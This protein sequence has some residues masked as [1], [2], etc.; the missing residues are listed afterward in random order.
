MIAYRRRFNVEFHV[1]RATGFSPSRSR[2][3]YLAVA[4][5]FA[6]FAW[7]SLHAAANETVASFKPGVAKGDVGIEAPVEGQPGE[8]PLAIATSGPSLMLLDQINGRVLSLD[9]NT[10][11]LR[12][13]LIPPRV[14]AGDLTIVDGVA[15]VWAGAPIRLSDDESH[16][17]KMASE[18]RQQTRN[19]AA[20]AFAQMGSE[21]PSAAPGAGSRIRPLSEEGSETRHEHLWTPAGVSSV[22]Y[23]L[24]EGRSVVSIVLSKSGKPSINLQLRAKGTFGS[25]EFLSLDGEERAYVLSEILSQDGSASTFVTRFT[26]TGALDA[27]YRLPY[28]PNQLLTTRPVA[29]TTAGDVLFLQVRPDGAQILKL[30]V[31]APPLDGRLGA[32]EPEVP[33]PQKVPRPAPTMAGISRADIVAGALAY[34]GAK[35]TVTPVAYGAADVCKGYDPSDRTR[36]PWYLVGH[37]GQVISGVPYSWG[38]CQSL[39]AILDAI[40]QGSAVAG[41]IC[42]K[43]PPRPNTAGVDCS[44]LVSQ[45]WD[46]GGQYTTRDLGSVSTPVEAKQLAPGDILLNPGSHVV[47]FLRWLPSGRI[48]DI[49]SATG[50][51]NGSVCRRSGWVSAFLQQ[52]YEPRKRKGLQ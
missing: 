23:T 47:I 14:K 51:C 2:H 50:R 37:L 5:I 44:G 26:A 21:E 38:G 11:S 52:G 35:F 4:L 43:E 48:E 36:R 39:S 28:A 16:I 45:A 24:R 46:L 10:K 13:I 32:N 34:E 27:I 30:D 8:G 3:C 29:I 42:T 25:V 31:M 9:L 15:F 18:D 40:K 41:N 49:E 12:S 20:T 22:A 1:E 6:G 7:S 17:G 33:P 19:L